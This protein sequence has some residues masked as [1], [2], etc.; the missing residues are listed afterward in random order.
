MCCMTC[1]REG[2]VLRSS[3]KRDSYYSMCC[4]LGLHVSLPHRLR[5]WHCPLPLRLLL[6]GARPDA[7]SP[8]GSK[9]LG[10]PRRLLTIALCHI[11][12]KRQVKIISCITRLLFL[13]CL[14]RLKIRLSLD[15]QTNIF[16]TGKTNRPETCSK[17]CDIPQ[18]CIWPDMNFD[19]PQCFSWQSPS[20]FSCLWKLHSGCLQTAL[21]QCPHGRLQMILSSCLASFHLS[22][23]PHLKFSEDE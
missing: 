8:P 20:V 4:P 15:L 3:K 12:K 22:G 16:L 23:K 6:G 9:A 19:I 5:P 14:T 17:S 1:G 10:P 11:K 2:E 18:H 13:R 21:P 7:L